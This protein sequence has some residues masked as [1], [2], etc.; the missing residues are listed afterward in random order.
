MNNSKFITDAFNA[1]LIQDMWGVP[2]TDLSVLR[3]HVADE[4]W[5]TI[6][7]KEGRKG[8][9]VKI[10][11]SGEILAGMG[12]KFNGRKINEIG[13]GSN[14][15][16]MS[17][18]E[19]E[20]KLTKITGNIESRKNKHI[21]SSGVNANS[22]AAGYANGSLSAQ[23]EE[24]TTAIYE[25]KKELMN[26]SGDIQKEARERNLARRAERKAERA[27]SSPK[28]N[29]NQST[30]VN[31][32]KHLLNVDI[33]SAIEPR[34]SKGDRVQIYKSDLPNNALNQIMRMSKQYGGFTVEEGGA[35]QVS[36]KFTK[37]GAK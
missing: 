17:T 35:G 3:K 25:I 6:N 30:I 19:L 28:L 24:E 37:G 13:K 22:T 15:S 34:F 7:N 31:R 32:I 5:I 20:N 2:Y 27:P 16:S 4:R 9:K 33:T 14:Y 1:G 21:K 18:S 10:S 11:A 23:T 36:L 12:G 29:E 8:S 26:R